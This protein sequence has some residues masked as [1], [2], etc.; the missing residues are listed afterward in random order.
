MKRM[1]KIIG[2]VFL[3]GTGAV[4]IEHS[5]EIMIHGQDEIV[6]VHMAIG[7][8]SG[9][10]KDFDKV[11]EAVN[12]RTRE[13]LGMELQLDFYDSDQNGLLEYLSEESNIDLL[14]VSELQEQVQKNILLP[15][16]EL[17]REEGKDI[18]DVIAPEYMELGKVDGRQYGILLNRDMASA[19]G[20]SMR[21]DLVEKYAIDLEEIQTWE[22]VEDV[23]E[24]VTR[25]EQ[26]YGIAADTLMPF[27]PLGNYLGVLM[28]DE[29]EMKV[30][31]Y[32]ETEEFY[33]WLKR[34]RSWKEK[35]YLYTKETVRYKSMSDRPFLYELLREGQLFAYIVKYKPG[36]NIM[37]S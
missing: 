20:V 1:Y 37:V 5:D 7:K 18:Y 12:E 35:G 29:K 32:Y 14:L 4:C 26:I 11:S 9:N 22:D 33:N 19:Y 31:N 17:L 34:I 25:E 6:T 16:D 24:T 21:K 10:M 28:S 36:I 23:L 3:L 30:V 2:A 27:D 8:P 13:A 15:L